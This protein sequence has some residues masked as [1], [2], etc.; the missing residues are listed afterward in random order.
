MRRTR[1]DKISQ[2]INSPKFRHKSALAERIVRAFNYCGLS[3]RKPLTIEEK[4]IYSKLTGLAE[5][6]NFFRARN[7]SNIKET[8]P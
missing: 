6:L 2:A 3:P 8:Q 5:K 1:I 4:I 7:R